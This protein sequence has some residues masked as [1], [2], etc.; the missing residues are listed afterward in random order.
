M[1]GDDMMTIKRFAR[2]T[3]GRDLVVGDIHG[4]F[5]KLQQA[6]DA[7]G[8]DPAAGD[9]L[10]S[11]GDLVDR[12]PESADVLWW[13]DQPWFAAVQGNHED[14]AIRWGLPGCRMDAEA[15]AL[16]GGAW[17][18]ANTA[19]ERLAISDALS[20]LPLAIELETV[21]GLVGIVHADCP[22]QTW[23]EFRAVAASD[24]LTPAQRKAVRQEVLWSRERIQAGDP[25]GVKGLQAL[26]VGH[27]PVKA[28]GC[29]GN[30]VYVDTGAWTPDGEDFALID[31]ATFALAARRE[32]SA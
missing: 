13:L 15:Y 3:A 27:T 11:V 32:V 18:I 26:F 23:D 31:V 14:M 17:N 8:F 7:V 20:A 1:G 25:S 12:G 16:N 28:P 9:R 21:A 6:L 24:S 29:L 10:F 30:V 5:S 22:F 2:N 4:H 19:P